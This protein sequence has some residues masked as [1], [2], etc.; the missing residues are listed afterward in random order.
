MF[1]TAI[2][3]QSLSEMEHRSFLY[4]ALNVETINS[5]KNPLSS[6]FCFCLVKHFTFRFCVERVLV[7]PAAH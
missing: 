1:N 4:I 7:K 6:L 5:V 3:Q 2:K